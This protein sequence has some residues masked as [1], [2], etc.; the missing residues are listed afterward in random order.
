MKRAITLIV[1]SLALTAFAQSAA[2]ANFY[3]P[4]YTDDRVDAYNVGSGGALT[5]LTGSPFELLNGGLTAFATTPDG[6]KGAVGYLFNPGVRG[7]TIAADGSIAAAQPKINF[8]DNGVYNAA[9][10]PDSRFAYFATRDNSGPS[11]AG[12][13]AYSFADTGAMT[14]LPGSPFA[15]DWEF[16]DVAV[17]PDQKFLYGTVGM[18][19]MVFSINADG[20]LGLIGNTG[21]I[22]AIWLSVSPDGRFVFVGGESGGDAAIYSFAI[23]A[24]GNLTQLGSPV[25]TPDVSGE[26]PTVAP[27]GKFVYMA[28]GNSDSIYGARVNPDGTL[29]QISTL[30]FTDREAEATVVSPDSKWLYMHTHGSGDRLMKSP[31]GP[32]GT[33]GP[34]QDIA[35]YDPGEPVRMHFRTGYGGVAK[36]KATPDAK[37]LSVTFDGSGSTAKQGPLGELEWTFD[38]VALTGPKHT[39]TFPKPGVYDV[40]LT[41]RDIGG[42]GSE[43]AWL[44]QTA[45]C[46][47]SPESTKTI[48]YDTPPWITSMSVS[49][50]SVGSKSK[51]KFKLTEKARV[52]FFAQKPAA[53]RLVGKSC[54]KPSAKN[55]KGKRCT[56]WLR[57]SKSF[58]ANGKKGSNSVKFTGKI[59]KS[60]L[61]R[62][63]YRIA[64]TAVDRA[65]G[66]SPQRTAAF[67]KR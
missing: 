6:R 18:G 56:R 24:S 31:I 26:M 3:A 48:K 58:R 2:A 51:I 42:C 41:A 50:K 49:P 16:L 13:R 33:L 63:R 5:P 40:S 46:M 9:V 67:R 61:K 57:A 15:T 37:P 54:R 65:K 17:T 22:T 29:T 39:R 19:L 7:A 55:R 25:V 30:T 1:L 21:G 38:G 66:K 62:G 20:T 44:G 8:A 35:A 36:F 14:E 32:D 27:N 60:T 45:P 52:T 23:E 28:E 59:G 12:V 11:V 47:G 64:A 53:G 34:A 10:S 4:I 43:R